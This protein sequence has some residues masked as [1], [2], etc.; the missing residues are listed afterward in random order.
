MDRV[1]GPVEVQGRQLHCNVCSNDT[2]WEH[3]VQLPTPF[4]TFLGI[5]EWN[6]V[7]QCAICERC[8]FIHWFAPPSTFRDAE[9]FE[10]VQERGENA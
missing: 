10:N 7:A 8:G 3:Q 1:F 5:E 2:F 6:R 9:P 4:F